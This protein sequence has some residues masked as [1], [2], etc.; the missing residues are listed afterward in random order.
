MPAVVIHVAG[1]AIVDVET[2]YD[3]LERHVIYNW[4]RFV[5]P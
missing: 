4:W 5:L 3:E 1:N 2:A